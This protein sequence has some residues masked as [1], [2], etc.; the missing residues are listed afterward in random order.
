MRVIFPIGN[1]YIVG[2]LLTIVKMIPEN[3]VELL[4]RLRGG[5]RGRITD[6][7]REMRLPISTVYDK[8]L[9]HRR[10]GIIKREV[11]LLDFAKLGYHSVA[12]VAIKV[13]GGKRKALQDHLMA[14]PNINSLYRVSYGHDFVAEVVVK[15]P[16]QLQDFLDD[17]ELRF[18]TGKPL[19]FSVVDE[20]RKESFL[21]KKAEGSNGV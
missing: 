19:V 7:A 13:S 9:R 21:G 8:M 17:L 11:M 12:L 1:G 5:V 2:N 3:D 20:M 16:A 6:I 10:E 14:H 18:E 15:N 4:A